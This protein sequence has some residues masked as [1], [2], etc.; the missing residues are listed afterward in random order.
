MYGLPTMAWE[1]SKWNELWKWF[2]YVRKT[3]TTRR[4]KAAGMAQREGLPAGGSAGATA[5]EGASMGFFGFLCL[6][7][8]EESWSR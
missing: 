1:S 6:R 3:S 5:G 2:E 4:A 7:D 8:M